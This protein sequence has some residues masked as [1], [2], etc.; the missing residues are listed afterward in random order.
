MIY[1]TVALAALVA[2]VSAAKEERTFAVLQHKSGGPLTE[3]RADPIVSPGVAASHVHTIMGASNFGLDVTGEQ[4]RKSNCTTALPKA[5]LSS[6][7]VP[8]LYFKDPETGKLEPV[9]F[10]YMNNY[11]L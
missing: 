5:D 1:T 10:Y 3:C 2:S 11:Y 6:Y 9:P 8:K 7:W 4:L